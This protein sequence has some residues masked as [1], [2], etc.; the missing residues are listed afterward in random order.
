MKLRRRT[1]RRR[2]QVN[3]EIEV[4]LRRLRRHKKDLR[5]SFKKLLQ[6]MLRMEGEAGRR[7]SLPTVLVHLVETAPTSPHCMS[8][9]SLDSEAKV[10]S[11]VLIIVLLLAGGWVGAEPS[12]MRRQRLLLLPNSPFARAE[13]AA[14]S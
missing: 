3:E 10:A 9:V 2:D 7:R 1:E 12:L 4:R 13:K 8:M 11:A 5:S 14:M 6:V